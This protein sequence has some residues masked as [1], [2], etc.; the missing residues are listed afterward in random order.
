MPLL[1]IQTNVACPDEK[2]GEMLKQISASVA[3]ML[4]KPERYVMVSFEINPHML[5]AG[6]ETPVAYLELKSI[7]LP[8]ERTRAF[9]DT[10]CGLISDHLG[11]A[12]ERIYIEFSNAA[13]HLWGWNSGT[14]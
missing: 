1:K 9:S 7:G 10:L 14:F 8:E 4:G 5:L 12:P 3:D 2:Q 13:R 6:E 11:I